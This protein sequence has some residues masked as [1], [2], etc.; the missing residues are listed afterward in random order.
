M[1]LVIG[2][3]ASHAPRSMRSG[4]DS[5]VLVAL[6]RQYANYGVAKASTLAKHRSLPSWRPLAP[7]ALV[8][9]T[10][11]GLVATRGWR[12]LAVPAVHT[13]ACVVAAVPL[14]RDPGVAPH[15]AAGAFAVC[16]WSYGYGFWSGVSRILRG[17][18]FDTRP[19]GHR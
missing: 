7:A 2:L 12:R 17:Q 16:H 5:A 4:S 10:A 3:L 14:A 1:P 15:R 6:S 8:A 9:A 19:R 18:R 11:V 13:A